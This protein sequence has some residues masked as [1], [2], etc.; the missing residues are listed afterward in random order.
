M[1]HERVTEPPLHEADLR[2]FWATPSRWKDVELLFGE[3]GACGGCWCMTWRLERG[4]YEKG[5]TGGNRRTLKKLVESSRRPGVIVYHGREPVAWCAVAP[6]EEYS[7]LA[8]SRVLAPVDDARVWSITCL[9]VARPWRRRGVSALLLRA[10]ARMAV[11]RGACIV[12]GYP[13]QPAA[14]NSPDPFVWT[15]LPSAFRKAGFREV[16]RRSRARPIMR[17]TP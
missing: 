7:F 10:A 4:A 2:F 14:E 12:E 15:G 16:L 13:Q 6:R 8:R 1:K 17:Y 5:K 9:F 11:A 3:R